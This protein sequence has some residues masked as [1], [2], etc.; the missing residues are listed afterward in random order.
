MSRKGRILIK[1]ILKK[2]PMYR[3]VDYLSLEESTQN[4]LCSIVQ[5]HSSSTLVGRMRY[6]PVVDNKSDMNLMY[7]VKVSEL[8]QYCELYFGF[9]DDNKEGIGVSLLKPQEGPIIKIPDP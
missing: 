3:N 1:D 6:I 5:K 9:F 8:K 7:T 4:D 2:N